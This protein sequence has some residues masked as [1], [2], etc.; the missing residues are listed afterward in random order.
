M[1]RRRM[2]PQVENTD[3]YMWSSTNDWSRRTESRS[4]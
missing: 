4:R 1:P 2:K 3:M